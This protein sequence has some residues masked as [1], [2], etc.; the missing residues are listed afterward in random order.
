MQHS[1]TLP[2]SD[3]S[4]SIRPSV[5]PAP[6]VDMYGAV[7]KGLRAFLAHTLALVGATDP[8]D[9]R[10]WRRAADT[11][12]SLLDVCE[13]HLREENEFVEAALTARAPRRPSYTADDHVEHLAAIASLRRG[14][15]GVSGCPVSAR[16]PRLG[17]LYLELAR[18]VAHNFEHMEREE[19]ENNAALWAAYT[20]DELRAIERALVAQIPPD[21]MEVFMS[22]MIPSMHHGERVAMLS[23]MRAGAPPEAF[24]HVM[25]IAERRLDPAD[26]AALRG[27]L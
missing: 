6:R 19:T 8:R 23:D 22:W 7:H 2:S 16:G 18:F 25:G 14:V 13:Q 20:D 3:H 15:E 27:A 5:A 9:E 24:A 17:R 11:L 4:P 26:F 21:K 1:A 12:T 10:A